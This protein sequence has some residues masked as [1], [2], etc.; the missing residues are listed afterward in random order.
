MHF[1][2]RKSDADIQELNKY[3]KRMSKATT[4]ALTRHTAFM[5]AAA[6]EN[7]FQLEPFIE[8]AKKEMEV[9]DDEE[10]NNQEHIFPC[11]Y[12]SIISIPLI[13][14][15]MTFIKKSLF[16]DKP[17]DADD[18]QNQMSHPY[19]QANYEAMMNDPNFHGY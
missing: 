18:Y 17:S 19:I 2:K 6:E 14:L 4:T 9:S 5:M 15:S 1:R 11:N 16:S 8:K 13:F 10:D 3:V 12:C 7:N